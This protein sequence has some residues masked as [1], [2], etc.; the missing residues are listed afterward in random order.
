MEKIN[1]V[2]ADDHILVRKGIKAM[3]ESEEDLNVVG[4]AGNG[5]EALEVAQAVAPGYS[6]ARY[7]H[8]GDDRA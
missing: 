7:P 3:L 5:K 1:I 8:A 2:L 4:E 6:G